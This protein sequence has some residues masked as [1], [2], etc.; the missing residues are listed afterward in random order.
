MDKKVKITLKIT[1]DKCLRLSN[2]K[3]TYVS[4]LSKFICMK[5]F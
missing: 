3:H 2:L 1:V 5:H 4:L